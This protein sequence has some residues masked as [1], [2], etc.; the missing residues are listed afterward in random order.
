M[1]DANVNAI[2]VKVAAMGLSRKHLGKNL[3]EVQPELMKLKD[4]YDINVCG[5]GNLF[6]C[7][8]YKV[9]GEFES[10]TLDCPLFKHYSI[11]LEE[12]ETVIHDPSP[13]AEVAYLKIKKFR[14][15]RKSDEN[16]QGIVED[17]KVVIVQPSYR[18]EIVASLAPLPYTP[19]Q[20]SSSCEGRV[21][22][23]SE[24][25]NFFYISSASLAA[26]STVS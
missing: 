9:G 22:P 8:F 3:S 26:I 14:L 23:M 2:L 4:M 10:F 19:S 24:Q 5:E 18:K 13:V 15:N 20:L 25:S 6:G 16:S 7:F 21:L 1:I 12:T 17:P 11:E